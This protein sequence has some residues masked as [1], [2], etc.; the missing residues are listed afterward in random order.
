MFFSGADASAVGRGGVV[1]LH[2]RVYA[3]LHPSRAHHRAQGPPCPRH[4][5]QVR[6]SSTN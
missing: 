6:T 4:Q 1:E 5:A 2:A 3:S